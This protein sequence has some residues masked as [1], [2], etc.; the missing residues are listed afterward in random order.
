MENVLIRQPYFSELDFNRA[1]EA[2][3]ESARVW[4]DTLV[5]Y[6]IAMQCGT[7]WPTTKELRSSAKKEYALHSQTV[8]ATIECVQTAFENAALLRK[9]H[10]QMGMRFPYKDKYHYPVHWPAQAV[11]F[12]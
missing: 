3:R 2:V 4:N 12:F 8:Q 6:H 9:T 11:T 5:Q 10:P 7:E 1:W